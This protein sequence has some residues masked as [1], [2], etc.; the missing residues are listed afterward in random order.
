[1]VDQ[2]LIFLFFFF[3]KES[4]FKLTDMYNTLEITKFPYKITMET[5]CLQLT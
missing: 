4:L 2:V 3:N 1:M 5:G